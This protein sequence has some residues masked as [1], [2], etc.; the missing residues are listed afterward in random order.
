MSDFEPFSNADCAKHRLQIAKRQAAEDAARAEFRRQEHPRTLV[1][2][3]AEDDRCS[4]P[5]I[6][7]RPAKHSTPTPMNRGLGIPKEEDE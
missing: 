3:L 4:S 1:D 6:I 5:P 2:F 7:E